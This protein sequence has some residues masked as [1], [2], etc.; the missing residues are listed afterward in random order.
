MQSD[1]LASLTT[2]I[3]APAAQRAE[4]G[5]RLTEAHGNPAAL[6]GVGPKFLDAARDALAFGISSSYWVGAAT[7]LAGGL[8]AWGLLRRV[9]AADA[10]APAVKPPVTPGARPAP[11]GR[12]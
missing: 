8:L 12:W 11:G 10:E 5:E 3:Q 1:K 6:T 4:L 9:R 2:S 7:L